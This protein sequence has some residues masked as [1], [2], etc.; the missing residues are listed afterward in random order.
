M[1]GENWGSMEV[2][3]FRS[4]NPKMQNV[5]INITSTRNSC[6]VSM[7]MDRAE[8][9]DVSCLAEELVVISQKYALPYPLVVVSACNFMAVCRLHVFLQ[10]CHCLKYFWLSYWF[11]YYLFAQTIMELFCALYCCIMS[12]HRLHLIMF[13][14]V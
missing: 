13:I 6:I 12:I 3:C 8:L 4:D 1:R 7:E 2:A 11:L 9:C 10:F 5:C 14:C